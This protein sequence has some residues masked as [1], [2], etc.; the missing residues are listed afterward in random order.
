MTLRAAAAVVCWVR[1]KLDELN[2]FHYMATHYL[3]LRVTSWS[4]LTERYVKVRD[5]ERSLSCKYGKKSL[6]VKKA[7]RLGGARPADGR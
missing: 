3:E 7:D 1:V 2:I 6:P 5:S 4:E